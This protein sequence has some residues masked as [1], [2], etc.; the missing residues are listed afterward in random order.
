[1]DRQY[2]FAPGN[3]RRWLVLTVI[4]GFNFKLKWA[5]KGREQS[6]NQSQIVLSH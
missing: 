4:D 3:A 5:R 2:L 1:M 6:I